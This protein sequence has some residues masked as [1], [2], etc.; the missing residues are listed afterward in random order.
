MNLSLIGRI[1]ELEGYTVD[2]VHAGAEA[3]AA[4][5]RQAPDLAILD[6]MMPDIDGYSLCKK[7]RMEKNAAD[8]PIVMLTAMNSEIERTRALEAGAN[9]IWSKPFDLDMFRKWIRDTLKSARQTRTNMK[10]GDQN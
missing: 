6:V 9:D 4:I 8:I 1:L 10:T 5:S 7:L 3:L 2:T